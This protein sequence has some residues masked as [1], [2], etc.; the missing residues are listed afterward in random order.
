MEVILQLRLS[1]SRQLPLIRTI[2]HLVLTVFITSP[3]GERLPLVTL[4]TRGSFSPELSHR[5]TFRSSKKLAV[6]V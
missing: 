4:L 6:E 3:S 1:L 2:T 5:L